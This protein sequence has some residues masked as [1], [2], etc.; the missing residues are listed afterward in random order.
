MFSDI[1]MYQNTLNKNIP[2]IYLTSPLSIEHFNKR[3]DGILI[4]IEE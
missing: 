3:I 2:K 1:E 4:P